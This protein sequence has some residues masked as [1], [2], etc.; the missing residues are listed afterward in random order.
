MRAIHIAAAAS[1][2]I[3]PLA[4]A[5]APAAAQNPI[6]RLFSCEQSGAK[7]EGGAVVGALLGAA[8]G[9]QVSKNERALGAVAGAALGAAAGSYI[10]CRM[11]STDQ[12]R[13]QAAT[14]LALDRG[15]S[16]V[17]TNPQTGASGRV[18]VLSS[19]YGPAVLG[20]NFRYEQGVQSLASYDALGGQYYAPGQVN[21]R[22]GPSTRAAV[23][24][25]LAPGERFDALCS[26]GGGSWVLVGRY[27]VAAGYVST[28]V[29]R[30]AG[31][32]MPANCRTVQTTNNVSGYGAQT[33]RFNACRD[34]RGEWQLTAI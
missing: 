17:W 8:L 32:P 25:K 20:T 23:V 7:Q 4:A 30:P 26:T 6:S 31:Q 5:P 28:S 10:G 14:K 11:Q 9:S 21:L 12:A 27:G 33:Q 19:S 18:D 22:G 34:T 15:G 2:V 1:L 29:V 13:A 24:G 16:E 3:A